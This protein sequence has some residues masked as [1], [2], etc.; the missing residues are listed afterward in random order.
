MN[1]TIECNKTGK[2]HWVTR[3]AINKSNKNLFQYQYIE[4]A[5]LQGVGEKVQKCNTPQIFNADLWN[6][7]HT[8]LDMF[9]TLWICIKNLYYIFALFHPPLATWL[10]LYTGTGID[11]CWIYLL[12]TWWPSELFQS[13]C[14]LWLYSFSLIFFCKTKFYRDINSNTCI[15]NTWTL[16][17]ILYV[18]YAFSPSS[19]VIHQ[20]TKIS[21]YF[22]IL[23]L[24]GT[25]CMYNSDK[26]L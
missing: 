6:C 14:I 2:A 10:F 4:I 22:A 7:L 1:T 5:R 15:M 25:T 13:C 24:I 18:T 21:R 8:S 3:W 12:L 23:H 17:K 9:M 20:L 11:F 16:K 26:N 19:P